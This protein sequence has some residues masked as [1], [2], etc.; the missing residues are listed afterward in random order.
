MKTISISSLAGLVSGLIAFFAIHWLWPAIAI[1]NF[2]NVIGL[3]AVI[4]AGAGAWWARS[5]KPPGDNGG[6][7]GAGLS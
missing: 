2:T 4:G 5:R 6:G 3:A 7:G 1:E